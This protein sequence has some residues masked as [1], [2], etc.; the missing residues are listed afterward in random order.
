MMLLIMG[1]KVYVYTQ[2]C[3]SSPLSLNVF[4]HSII[5][6]VRIP[7]LSEPY[8]TTVIASQTLAQTFHRCSVCPQ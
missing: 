1:I 7:I 6:P 5:I 2:H 4:S 3:T 8:T